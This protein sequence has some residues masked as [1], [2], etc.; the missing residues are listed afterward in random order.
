MNLG[1]Y[2][3]YHFVFNLLKPK[4]ML[5]SKVLIKD[6]VSKTGSYSSKGLC[7]VTNTG[8]FEESQVW[9]TTWRWTSF[10]H[11]LQ[12]FYLIK[13]VPCYQLFHR[14]INLYFIALY[15][16]YQN[17]FYIA[18]LH[19]LWM[20]FKSNPPGL[21]CWLVARATTPIRKGGSLPKCI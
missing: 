12:L 17:W 13:W 4:N 6:P 7:D 5:H 18:L 19:P 9:Y 16:Q 20:Y 1:K 3:C 11:F 8:Q 14:K 15:V 21:V 2:I 10:D